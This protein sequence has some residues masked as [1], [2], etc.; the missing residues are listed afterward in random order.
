MTW[1]LVIRGGRVVDGTGR[2]AQTADV[3][4]QGGRIAAVGRLDGAARRELD[5]DGLVVTPGFIDVHTH[6]DAQLHWDPLATPA[7]WHGVT[8]VLTGNCGFT[9]AP[10]KPE[11]VGWLAQMLSRVEGMS[12]EALAAGMRWTGGSFADFWRALDGRIAVNAGSYVGHSAV[13]RFVMGDDASERAAR[14]AEITAMGS[15]FARPCVPA[16]SASA[17]R[18][19]T[20]TSHTT[21]A[22]CPRTTPHPRS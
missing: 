13:R 7:S 6:Y 16:H 4:V 2:P 3:A 9:L 19:S 21:G 8:T 5:A 12:A 18:S 11:D 22:V 20:S 1:D 14:P 17:R 15:R 10:A